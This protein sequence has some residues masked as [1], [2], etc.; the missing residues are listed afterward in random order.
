MIPLTLAEIAE[1]TGG[2]LVAGS[3]DAAEIVVSA[4]VEYDSRKLRAG[5]LFA[6]F[7]G[8]TADGH[9]FA[10]TAVAS[11]AV[12]VLGSR[13]VDAAP[14]VV[15]PDVRDAMAAL[16]RHVVAGIPGLTV[17]AVTGS[18]GKTT[19]KDMLAGLLRRLGPTVST[20]GTLNNELGTPYTA[21]QAGP[22]TRYLVLEMSARGVGHIAYLCGIAPPHI[23]VVLNVGTAHLGE[24]GSV[25]AIAVAK[26]ELVEALPSDG[27]AVLNA[28]DPRV[29]DMAHR[30]KGS[31]RL[32]GEAA[33]ADVRAVDVTE[34]GGGLY[35]YT[36]E[37]DGQREPVRLAQAGR[38]QVA[39]SVLAATVAL[40]LGMSLADT[41]AAVSQ[42]RPASARR[43][44][45][46][47]RTDGITVI[48]DS[49]NANPASMGAALR[50]LV[51]VG[52]GRRTF[53][54]LGYM[55]ELGA[56]E[57]AGHAEMGRLAA[58][59]GVDR[60]VA[61]GQLTAPI[62]RG[63]NEVANWG[64]SS[65]LVTDQEAATALLREELR[66]GDVVLVKGSRYR[67]WDVVDA[68]REGAR[69]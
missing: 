35:T 22:G 3:D 44:D 67:T 47:E 48:D 32:A 42:L 39:N 62:D 55:A 50:T 43:M 14:T 60:V 37:K 41:A 31:V 8:E 36:L 11:G 2:R 9:D 12:A 7:V 54:V 18:S 23:S 28:D 6:A 56:Y 34:A 65:V 10:A 30:T 24:F 64:G 52:A 29:R 25:D 21:L 1:I 27:V 66:S 51:S 63:A 68:L 13:P 15:V 20:R 45:I 46:F 26:G 53:A 57:E 16:A 19:T 17:V 61:V 69:A 49:Y 40:E 5:G 4:P 38:H 33:D 59:L 58:E